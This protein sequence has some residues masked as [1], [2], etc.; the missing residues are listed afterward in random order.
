M[1]TSKGLCRTTA[2]DVGNAGRQ[3]S[4]EEKRETDEERSGKKKKSTIYVPWYTQLRNELD[5]NSLEC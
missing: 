3:H 5:T 2:P 1:R 4:G